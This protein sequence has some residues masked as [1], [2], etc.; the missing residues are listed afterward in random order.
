MTTTLYK[1]SVEPVRTDG[2]DIDT[3]I[4]ELT[5]EAASQK[6]AGLPDQH[7]QSIAQTW[8]QIPQVD[9]NDPTYYDRPMLKEPVWG[10]PIPTYYYVGGLTGASLALGAAAQIGNTGERES[11]ITRCHLIGFIGATISSGLLIYDLG[12][13][14]RFFNMLRVFRPTS[15][16]N[17]GA[18]ILSIT[19][20]ASAGTVLFRRRRGWL[21]KIDAV[22]GFISGIAGL[23]LATYTGVLVANSAVPLWQASRK[24]LPVLFG[25]SAVASAG[26]FFDIFVENAG[27]RR[28]TTAFGTVGRIA[29]IS[30]GLI[31]E[32]QAS[33][34]P[35]V[36]LPLK[37]GLSGFLWKTATLCTAASLAVSL[38]R[39]QTKKTRVAAGVLGTLG[40]LV[41]RFTVQHAGVLSARD[42]R[43]SFYQQRAGKGAAEATGS[44][45]L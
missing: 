27:E 8:E 22:L 43:A 4:A 37:R 39:H 42:A 10:W 5:G 44:R 12:R 28:I 36:G 23:A 34:V 32:K 14:A 31:M 40:S 1:D 33:A 20:A 3:A 24:A 21:A 13:P 19:G 38:L 18:W 26:S 11:L 16:M 6:S 2:R 25:A 45:N 35:R 41:M 7:I 9:R 17:V 15:P 29:E 30:A